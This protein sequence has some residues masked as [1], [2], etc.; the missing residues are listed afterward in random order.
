MLDEPT[1]AAPLPPMLL[2]LGALALI[3][4]LPAPPAADLATWGPLPH[5]MPMVALRGEQIAYVRVA[6]DP[7]GGAVEAVRPR[8]TWRT[9]SARSCALTTT[10]A[11]PESSENP[12]K[13]HH[14]R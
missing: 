1:L 7:S 2:V 8:S 3:E 10:G 6:A 4:P 12:A 11:P 13:D 14:K 9:A 5:A